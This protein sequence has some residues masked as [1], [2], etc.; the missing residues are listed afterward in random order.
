M[1][2]PK[3]RNLTFEKGKARK[4]LIRKAKPSLLR[5]AKHLDVSSEKQDPHFL[6]RQN[7]KASLNN[8]EKPGVE[9]VNFHKNGHV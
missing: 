7:T 8:I 6:E 3:S 2:Y 4:C 9:K 1:S 5:K